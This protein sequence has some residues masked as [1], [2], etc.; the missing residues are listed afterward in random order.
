M[1]TTST[2]AVP[3]S[4]SIAGQDIAALLLRLALGTMFI[5]HGL[6]KLL[7]W[8]LAGTGQFFASIGLPAWVAWP[9]TGLELAGGILLILGVR[10]RWVALILAFELAGAS[11]PHIANGWMFTSTGGGWEYPVF[12]AATALALSFLDG[13]KL[14]VSRFVGQR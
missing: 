12:L 2:A 6:T 3:V 13:G 14:T 11:M 1:Q 7:V 5:A 4:T 9:I 10:V 8:T